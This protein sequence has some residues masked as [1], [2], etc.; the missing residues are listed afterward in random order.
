M[1]LFTMFVALLL[2]CGN[3]YA[4]DEA[5]DRIETPHISAEKAAFAKTVLMPG[6]PLRA[7][8][9]SPPKSVKP[10]LRR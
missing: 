8:F 10:L 2:T 6:D 4:Q 1:K 7:K 9:N 5:S 3:A